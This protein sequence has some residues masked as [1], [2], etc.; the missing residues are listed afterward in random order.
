MIRNEVVDSEAFSEI[1]KAG[2]LFVGNVSGCEGVVPV[3]GKLEVA[4][5]EKEAY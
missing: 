4:K 5:M 3:G 2:D 1:R